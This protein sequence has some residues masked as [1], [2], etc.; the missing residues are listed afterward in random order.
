MADTEIFN[1]TY[2]NGTTHIM[3]NILQAIKSIKLH[4]Q[5]VNIKHSSIQLIDIHR[6]IHSPN[7]T[8]YDSTKNILHL[9]FIEVI[10]PGLYTLK[11]CTTSRIS[12]YDSEKNI[13]IN[14]NY[15]SN[16]SQDM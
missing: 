2:F 6:T 16:D 14:T 5:T 1:D 15:W 7:K 10:Y 13:F 12:N 3:I 4:I 8:I 9:D 11:I